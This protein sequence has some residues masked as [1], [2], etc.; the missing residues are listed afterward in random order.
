M[1]TT[2]WN[3]GLPVPSESA[4][5][6]TVPVIDAAVPR[7]TRHDALLPFPATVQVVVKLLA[8][9]R[10]R[11]PPICTSTMPSS[12]VG[13]EAGGDDGGGVGG[14]DGTGGRPFAKTAVQLARHGVL[15]HS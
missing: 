11:R 14:G 2:Q 9:K 3:A 1:S 12:G 8:L 6:F 15:V 7:V 4:I 13:G 5:R 10:S